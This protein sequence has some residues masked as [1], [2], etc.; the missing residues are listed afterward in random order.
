MAL[1]LLKEDNFSSSQLNS[2]NDIA[3][4]SV[5]IPGNKNDTTII[6]SGRIG[7]DG[8]VFYLKLDVLKQTEKL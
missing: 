2:T 5:A 3:G 6:S 7:S 1:T 4:S 8:S